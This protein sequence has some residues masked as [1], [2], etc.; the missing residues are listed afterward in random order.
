MKEFYEQNKKILN[1]VFIVV[2]ILLVVFLLWN[3]YFSKLVRFNKQVDIVSDAGKKYF[4]MYTNK[5]P[6]N[7]KEVSTVRVKE[8]YDRKFVDAKDLYI[9]KTKKGCDLNNSFVKARKENGKIEYYTYLKCGSFENKTDHEGPIIT[10]N[11][12]MEVILDINEKYEEK[13]IKSVIDKKDGNI[14]VGTVST[15]NTTID[16]SKVGTYEIS[17]TAYDSLRNTTTV[18]RTVKVVKKL[19]GII[20]EATNNKN[21]YVGENPNNYVQFSG[22]LFRIVG[23]NKDGTIKLMSSDYISNVVYGDQKSF[24]KTNIYKWLN[25]YYYAHL[26]SKK[27][28]V[29]SDWCVGNVKQASEDGCN[30][31]V[32]AN[33]GLLTLN[34]YQRSIN[35]NTSYA[36]SGL[37]ESY[38]LLN[39]KDNNNGWMIKEGEVETIA[40][41]DI[42]TTRP[43][44]NIKNT[45]YV[46][47][48]DGSFEK[49]YILDDYKIGKANSKLTD[50]LI[51]EYVQYS[52][53][54]W[55]VLENEEDGTTLIMVE[56]LHDANAQPVLITY[57]E[58]SKEYKYNSKEKENIGYQIARN[59]KNYLVDDKKIMN[60]EWEIVA[61]DH[62]KTYDKFKTSTYKS[63]YSIPKSYDMFSAALGYRSWLIDYSTTKGNI[64]FVGPGGR[65]FDVKIDEARENAVKL[66]I[67]LDNSTR[68]SSGSGTMIDPYNVK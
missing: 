1:I 14:D 68:I 35:E 34:E 56:S 61:F 9:P 28:V 48:G 12:D 5:L 10:L 17:Y 64:L 67:K 32:K 55:R 45:L 26:A 2:G 30:T 13:G 47:N 31:K 36:S 53:Q 19:D 62:T 43:V 57:D 42:T 46:E 25:D 60:N 15:N 63:K 65:G 7:E 49:P 40:T 24:D 16:T 37:M 6:N 41:K 23:I 11:G 8:L 66:V 54:L 21:Y 44:I 58:N 52:D 3:F 18:K 4:G 20:K 29:K 33:V 22:M 38:W 27:D 50:R 59:V 51:G 39:R